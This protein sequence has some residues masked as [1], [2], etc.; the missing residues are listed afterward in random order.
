MTTSHLDNPFRHLNTFPLWPVLALIGLVTFYTCDIVISPDM[1]S[2]MNTALNMYNGKG[3]TEI[4]GSLIFVR[5]PLFPA[6]I[7]LS[8]W[9]FDP[10]AWSAFWVVRVFCILNPIVIYFLG[11]TLYDKWTGFSA[12]LLILSSYSLN[13]WS[14]R[15]I[16]PVWSF[17]ALFSILMIFVA[18]KHKKF[19]YFFFAGVLVGIGYLA[20]ESLVLFL[21]LPF[22]FLIFIRN[23]RN[24]KNLAGIAGFFLAL[25]LVLA[26][27]AAY[28]YQHTESLSLSL[29]GG[30]GRWALKQTVSFDLYTSVKDLFSGIIA[31]YQGSSSS[32]VNNFLLAPLFVV[33][34]GMTG[35]RA[36]R[37]CRADVLLGLVLLLSMPYVSIVGR[38]DFRLGQLIFLLFLS[39]LVLGKMILDISRWLQNLV[40]TFIFEFRYA[41]IVLAVVFVGII[42][43]VQML[44]PWKQDRGNL[45]FLKRG[46]AWQRLVNGH[47]DFHVQGQF[48]QQGKWGPDAPEREAARWINEHIPGG[49][50]IIVSEPSSGSPLFFHT[51]GEYPVESIPVVEATAQRKLFIET[52]P[53]SFAHDMGQDSDL[54]FMSSKFANISPHNSIYVLLQKPFLSLIADQAIGYVY[55]GQRR[56]F[57]TLYFDEHPSFGEVARF[58][59]GKNKLFRISSNIAYGFE[60]TAL[61]T[62]RLLYYLRKMKRMDQDMFTWYA[63]NLFSNYADLD[64]HKIESIVDTFPK[65]KEF[66]LGRHFRVIS[67]SIVY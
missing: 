20:K 57:L 4:N 53:E 19:I 36:F 26:P 55:V 8:Y 64:K 48:H 54:I 5:G 32:L 14:Y 31:Y 11:K 61:I 9:F 66:F 13:Y 45:V 7:A 34:W 67:D 6:L 2:Y 15:H 18:F 12:A 42:A 52:W 3:Y 58:G 25:F 24:T 50:K 65:S 17:F 27:W 46:Y 21:P 35:Y 33:A 43:G 22:L 62:T 49:E 51:K 56:N 29:F 41:K 28:V 30:P 40:N 10:S 60:P 38:M 44:Y 37:G 1:A 47:T 59:N 39:Y 63:D 23:N 16:D